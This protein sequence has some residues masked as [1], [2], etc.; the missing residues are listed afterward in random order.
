MKPLGE[1]LGN[2]FCPDPPNPNL[3]LPLPGNGVTPGAKVNSN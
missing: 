3:P 1:V 2:D